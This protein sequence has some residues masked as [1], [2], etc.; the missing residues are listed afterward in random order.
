M[1]FIKKK[2]E[3][4][5]AIL[6]QNIFNT[7]SVGHSLSPN[8][9][10][11]VNIAISG[12]STRQDVLDKVIE[13]CTPANTAHRRYLVAISLAWSTVKRRKEAII[14]IKYYLEN[15]LYPGEYD[16]RS[17]G[18]IGGVMSDSKSMHI[19]EMYRYLG[20]AY[21]GEY[22][23]ENAYQAFMKAV[24]ATP[25]SVSHYCDLIGIL[26]KMNRLDSARQ[27]CIDAQNLPYYQPY[28]KKT[29]DG[30]EYVD[31]SFKKV[32]D[33]QLLD[34]DKKIEKRYVYKPRK[35]TK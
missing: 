1:L 20:K 16:N 25:Y 17:H 9:Q 24:D 31:G 11:D 15:P 3:D 27:V 13:L 26:I 4:S 32:I 18:R 23:F 28:H 7:L 34:I 10:Q 6:A 35:Q 5:N 33:A 14:A 8:E 22:Q 12:C 19:S 2:Q 30:K 21:E 29:Y